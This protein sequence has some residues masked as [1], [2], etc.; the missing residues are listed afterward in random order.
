[1][2]FEFHVARMQDQIFPEFAVR[3]NLEEF[4]ASTS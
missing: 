2:L 4:Q 1:M 3:P